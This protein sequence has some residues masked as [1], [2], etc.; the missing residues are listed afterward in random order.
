M[1]G[2]ADE[3]TQK[4]ICST[5]GISNATKLFASPNRANLR[6]EIHKVPK[7]LMLCKLDWIVNMLKASNRSMPKTIIFCDTIYALTSVVNYLTMQLGEYTFYPNS[8]RRRKDCLIGIFHS[9][10]QDKYK[11]RI[12]DS[13]KGNG[14]KRVVVATSALSMGVNFPDVKY[15]IMHGPPRN[16]LDFHQQAG[17]AGRDGLLAHTVLFYYGQQLTHVEDDMR[18]FLNSCGICFRVASY[19]EFDK[20]IT[21]CSPGHMCCNIC[22]ETCECG[23]EDCKEEYV[24]HEESTTNEEGNPPLRRVVSTEDKEMLREALEAHLAYLSSSSTITTLG[25][26]CH[27]FSTEVISDVLDNCHMLFTVKDIVSCIPVFSV[28]HGKQILSIVN[29]VFDDIDERILLDTESTEISEFQIFSFNDLLL[30][31]FSDTSLLTEIPE[32]DFI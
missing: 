31:E 10:I 16:L 26:S 13:L 6:F 24:P 18:E 8:S 9:M 3:V 29:E 25:S 2:T 22:A 20:Y 1:T 30:S 11:K 27:D 12:F 32:Y 14:I 5:F 19:R 15:V 28:T 4:V 21:P 7:N 23:S 17:K